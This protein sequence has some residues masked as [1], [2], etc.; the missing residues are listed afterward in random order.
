MFDRT[1][2]H[3]GLLGI[4]LAVY[5]RTRWQSTLEGHGG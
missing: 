5:R 4:D 2:H 3:F 1:D